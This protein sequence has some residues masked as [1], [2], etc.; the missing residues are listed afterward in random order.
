MQPSDGAAEE[1]LQ[2]RARSGDVAAF[3]RLIEP[4]QRTLYAIAVRMLGDD[5]SAA[6]VTQE[7]LLAAWQHLTSYHGGNFRAWLTRILVNRCYDLL[8]TRRRRP[9]RS[10][11]AILEEQPETEQL[12]G[13]AADPEQLALSS[14]LGR[15]L[16]AGLAAL[17][18]DQRA[19]VILCDVQ[20]YAYA[21]AAEV[22]HTNI[23]TVKSRLSRGR[24]RLRDW[25][26]ER[27]ELL[28]SGIRSVYCDTEGQE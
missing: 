25:L 8:R 27:P 5:A 7:S 4:H 28:P 12:A 26:A 15:H 3:N 23:G 20:G 14:E 13:E 21:E 2:A 19:I 17:P 18:P 9:E 22:E 6:D 11:D 1:R 24:A 10:Y 16:S